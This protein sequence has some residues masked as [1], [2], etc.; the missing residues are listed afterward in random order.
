MGH[1]TDGK[2][3]VPLTEKFKIEPPDLTLNEYQKKSIHEVLLNA[4]NI[5][6]I[7]PSYGF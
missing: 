2:G 5:F 4:L 3:T 7:I 6:V 1:D